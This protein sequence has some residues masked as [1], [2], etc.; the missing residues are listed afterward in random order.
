LFEVPDWNL[1]ASTSSEDNWN[2]KVL[3]ETV[4]VAPN[5][6]VEVAG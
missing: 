6:L 1:K 3:R 5:S 2:M 4:E